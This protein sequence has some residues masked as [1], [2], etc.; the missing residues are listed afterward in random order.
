MAASGILSAT[1]T[2]ALAVAPI[3]I[4]MTVLSLVEIAIPLHR[5]GR[6]NN[7]HLVPNLTLTFVT[8]GM[9]FFFNTA[10]L[11]TLAWL[12]AAHFGL[13]WQ[14]PLWPLAVP[15]V[16]IVL[17]D[18]ATYIAHVSMHKIP[19]MWRFHSIHHCDPA[20][21]VTTTIRQHPGETVIRIGAMTAMAVALGASPGTFVAYRVTSSMIGLAEHANIA[22]PVWLDTFLSW[23]TT[24]PNMHKVHHSRSPQYTD[25][26]YGNVLSLWDRLFGTFTPARIGVDV[27]YGLEGFDDRAVQATHGLLALPF[28]RWRSDRATPETANA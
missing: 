13:L 18:L 9:N 14:L 22:L 24:S 17:L 10:V 6:A 5:R 27:A 20:L 4:G 21:D 26:N 12:Q 1:I 11:I 25:T 19:A 7:T 15:V 23:F 8:L 28:R 16:V 3:L 2:F